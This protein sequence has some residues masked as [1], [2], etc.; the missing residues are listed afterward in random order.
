MKGVEK[1]KYHR[2]LKQRW[3]RQNQRL[4]TVRGQA[5]TSKGEK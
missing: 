5:K 2:W 4:R 3:R 1:G